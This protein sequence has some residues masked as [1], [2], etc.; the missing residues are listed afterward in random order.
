[1][2]FAAL[3]LACAPHRVEPVYSYEPVPVEAPVHP[4]RTP[5][6]GDV[7]R[8]VELLAGD[9]A[10]GGG[11]LVPSDVMLDCYDAEDDRDA[12]H[13]SYDDELAARLQDRRL[14]EARAAADGET[15]EQLRQENR[16]LRWAGL[17]LGAAGLAGGLVV[18]LVAGATASVLP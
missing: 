1:M 17:G 3:L 7:P 14:A 16:A 10:P 2:L 9:V 11:T 8:P 4:D 5:A 12:W 6:D 15:I 18:G 13:R